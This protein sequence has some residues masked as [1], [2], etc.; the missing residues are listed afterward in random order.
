MRTI[1][2][3]I[4]PATCYQNDAHVR[5]WMFNL[6][7]GLVNVTILVWQAWPRAT[8]PA[9]I[10]FSITHD[11]ASP[12]PSFPVRDTESDP[13][14]G[15]LGLACE[16]RIHGWCN[17]RWTHQRSS[18]HSHMK[19]AVWFIHPPPFHFSLNSLLASPESNKKCLHVHVCVLL[20]MGWEGE[21][22]QITKYQ[23][24]GSTEY[25]Y[26]VHLVFTWLSS[27]P[28]CLVGCAD[29]GTDSCGPCS[30]PPPAMW[31]G[32]WYSGGPP[33][34]VFSTEL[35]GWWSLAA[36]SGWEGCFWRGPP[37]ESFIQ[38]SRWCA[39]TLL[40]AL[41]TLWEALLV[42]GHSHSSCLSD[43][44]KAHVSAAWVALQDHI[45]HGLLHPG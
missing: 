30:E 22:G 4:V 35:L 7:S 15:W 37:L 3:T 13:R 32:V 8:N 16:T 18:I 14:W 17:V 28:S 44:F 45:Y 2:T 39:A 5:L 40:L 11:R 12:D 19:N 34:A 31:P 43:H 25:T 27:L 1:W 9:R 6:Y 41:H 26:T 36:L 33:P 38:T 21:E 20:R 23:V 29:P 10:A 42:G 24:K